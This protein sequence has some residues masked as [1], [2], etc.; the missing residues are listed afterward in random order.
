MRF[1]VDMLICVVSGIVSSI[2][3]GI[4]LDALNKSILKAFVKIQNFMDKLKMKKLVRVIIMV[5][6]IALCV[7]IKE[8]YDL[9]YIKFGILLGFFNALYEIIF[10]TSFMAAKN[11]NA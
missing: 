2:I 3:F 1:I 10:K 4:L 5:I 8:F 7:E 11:E 9:N 6:S